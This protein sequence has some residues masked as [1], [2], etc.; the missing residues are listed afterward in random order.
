MK[1]RIILA[2]CLCV[3]VAA[4]GPRGRGGQ[5]KHG[6]AVYEYTPDK[7]AGT[8]SD[9]TR[10]VE[11]DRSGTVSWN[12]AKG[13]YRFQSDGA[14]L[15]LLPAPA[16]PSN[17]FRYTVVG[18]KLILLST[19]TGTWDEFHRV[20]AQGAPGRAS[21]K[22][23]PPT[24]ITLPR[25]SAPVHCI[26]FGPD[27][28]RLASGS[29]DGTVRI[30][31]VPE[32]TTIAT[33]AGHARRIVAIAFSP[34]GR[35]LAT[36][37][38][39]TGPFVEGIKPA[40]MGALI[41]KAA[42]D[43]KAAEELRTRSRKELEAN[44]EASKEKED[45]I[46]LWDLAAGNE[47]ATL[48][49]RTGNANCLAFSPDGRMLASGGQLKLWNI[50]TQKEAVPI[51]LPPAVV[52][53]VGF[54]AD[55]RSLASVGADGTLMLWDAADGK[56]IATHR[57]LSRFVASACVSPDA[58][59]IAFGDLASDNIEFFESPSGRQLATLEARPG[60]PYRLAFS[61]DGKTL[62]SGASDIKLWH[63]TTGQR[64]ATLPEPA[65][66]LA[67]SPDGK[68]LAFAS[69]SDANVIKLWRLPN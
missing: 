60:T 34:D 27:G 52:L 68:T 63:V 67:F 25:S 2:A 38:E 3:M 41:Q 50:G 49:G 5:W 58:R 24:V 43:P 57:Q 17:A 39:A 20:D 16:R 56:N 53:S 62:A 54:T 69:A 48:T 51:T 29:A 4:C 44:V 13:T 12:K 7:L 45:N 37:S 59:T 35:M 32:T 11:F 15:V 14:L 28:K 40:E 30:W 21:A 9:G 8:W 31:D 23:A 26:A 42:K 46:K 22:A 55:G 65:L 33:L 6:T 66:C 1:R 64:V 47:I 18:D 61:A 36:G 19:Q 10:T